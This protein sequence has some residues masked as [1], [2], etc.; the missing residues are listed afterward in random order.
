MEG[1][2]RS[3][4]GIVIKCLILRLDFEIIIKIFRVVVIVFI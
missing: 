3:R 1:Y 2:V 4:C